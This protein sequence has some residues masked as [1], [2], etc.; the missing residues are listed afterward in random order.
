MSQPADVDR[1]GAGLDLRVAATRGWARQINGLKRITNDDRQALGL[2]VRDTTPTRIEPPTVA[3][4]VRVT[5]VKNGEIFFDLRQDGDLR[6]KPAGV[7]DSLVFT[8]VGES[9]PT[10]TK[11]WTYAMT[12][13]RTNVKLPFP[14]GAG[15]TTLWI[16]AFWTNAKGQS[17]PSS[18]PVSVNLPAVG[19][20]P[21]QINQQPDLKI[22]A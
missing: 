19:A 17:G 12:T 6:A 2:T 18:T 10:D 11:Q 16:A 9:A 5:N 4:Y 3:P 1:G 13:G 7:A 15:G 14:E 21:S 8:F 20:G 22:A